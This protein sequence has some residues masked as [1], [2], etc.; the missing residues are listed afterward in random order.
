MKK[1]FKRL[2]YRIFHPKTPAITPTTPEVPD[3]EVPEIPKPVEQPQE[4]HG[5]IADFKFVDSSHHHPYFDPKAYTAPILSNK[6]TQGGSFVDKTH[7]NRKKLCE[8]NGIGYSGYH[9]YECRIDPI[10][11]AQF[12]VKTHGTF[13]LPPQVDF[14]TADKVQTEADLYADKEDL[15]KCLCEIER[16]TGMTPWLYL[17]YGAAKRLKFSA[18]FGIFFAWFARYNSFLGEI[19]LPWT[20]ET[21]AAWQYTE[22]GA[23]AGFNGGN[24]VNI[25]YGKVNA[26]NLKTK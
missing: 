20:A 19:P 7:A 16:L 1:F 3:V 13:T 23:F 5:E 17:N 26:L 6:C 9:F 22:K 15:Y 24:D 12:Y 4:S 14:E 11:Q 21:T 8:D 25:Y 2:W 10:I 18:K